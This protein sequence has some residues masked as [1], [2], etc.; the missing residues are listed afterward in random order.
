MLCLFGRD[1]NAHGYSTHLERG[2]F[3]YREQKY[4]EAER[5]Y[6]ASYDVCAEMA[7]TGPRMAACHHKLGLVELRLGQLDSAALV[8]AVHHYDGIY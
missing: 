2:N 1:L 8:E 5:S 4:E 3:A 7:P 6:R